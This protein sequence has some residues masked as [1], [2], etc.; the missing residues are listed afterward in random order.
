MLNEKCIKFA[1]KNQVEILSVKDERMRIEIN[2]TQILSKE[3]K[4]FGINYSNIR[5]IRIIYVGNER[6]NYKLYPLI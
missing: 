4:H 3:I 5:D 1:I 6:T 2:V